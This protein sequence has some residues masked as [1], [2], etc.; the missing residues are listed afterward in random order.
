MNLRDERQDSPARDE[1]N[2][3]SLI[4]MTA[5]ITASYVAKNPVAPTDLPSLV[6]N[7]HQAL[8]WLGDTPSQ[9]P[10]R[11]QKPAVPI[12]RSVQP[13]YIVCLEDG[14]KLQMLKRHLRTQYNMTPE[15]YR[16]KWNL[17]HDY[18]MVAPNYSQKRSSFAKSIGLGTSATKPAQKHKRR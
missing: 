2:Q 4:R 8:A 7:V 18:P 1:N 14:R 5:L 12:K 3:D 13:D 16:A 6:H 11:Q 10:P 15:D 9:E 17:P